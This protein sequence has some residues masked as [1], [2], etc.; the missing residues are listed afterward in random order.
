MVR[1]IILLSLFLIGC[2]TVPKVEVKTVMVPTLFC[3]A[4]PENPRPN[5]PIYT[6]SKGDDIGELVIKYKATI[7]SLQDFSNRQESIIRMYK[8]LSETSTSLKKPHQIEIKE[9]KTND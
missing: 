9:V 4:P 1:S 5:L 6:I 8:I 2:S 7:R 3:P